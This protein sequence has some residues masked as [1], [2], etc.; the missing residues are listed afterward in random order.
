MTLGNV[1]IW[2]VPLCFVVDL[3]IPRNRISGFKRSNMGSVVLEIGRSALFTN[4]V[5][6][7]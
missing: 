5:F 6:K 2:V 4:S 7:L 3:L 1:H